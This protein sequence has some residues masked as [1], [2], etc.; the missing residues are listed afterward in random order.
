MKF[1]V[2]YLQDQIEVF[3]NW[4]DG[5]KFKVVKKGR[6]WGLTQGAAY[7]SVEKLSISTKPLK[8]LWGETINSNIE[9][10]FERY[11]V[12]LMKRNG[13]KYKWDKRDK[14]LKINDSYCDFRSADNPEN[15]EGFGYDEI[16]LNEAGIILKN[17][18]L[19][20]NTILPMMLDNPKSKI[21]VGGVP[22]GKF[23][24]SGEEH[25][26]YTIYK[27]ALDNPVTH[28][29]YTFSSYDNPILSQEQIIE[30]EK[31]IASLN[32]DQVLQEIYGEF[33]AMDSMDVFCHAYDEKLHEDNTIQFNRNLPTVFSVDF[34]LRPF[35]CQI[36]NIWEDRN[37]L[38]HYIVDEISIDEGSI[39]AMI[40]KIRQKYYMVLDSCMLT[41]DY[42]GVRKN[43]SEVDLASYYLQIERGLGLRPSQVKVSSNPYHSN[44]HSQCNYF[45]TYF[46][47]FKINPETCPKS[48]LD[49]KLVKVDSYGSI[50]KRDRK[51]ISQRADFLDTFRYTV[52]NFHTKWIDIHQKLTITR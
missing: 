29:T 13:V 36:A 34:N 3:F 50:I 39:P 9:K 38:H 47:D 43:I 30:L 2:E 7:T 18:S 8:L 44:S 5:L 52:H 46:P 10:Y 15:W 24:K 6:R 40:E 21:V 22:K 33:I 12:P 16:F 45:L 1:Q 27:R 32:K 51:D 31:E 37:G 14:V 28:K 20:V 26:F 19:Y 48:A 41:G 49:M 35:A 42:M 17:K 4:P 23:L 11:F 25:P